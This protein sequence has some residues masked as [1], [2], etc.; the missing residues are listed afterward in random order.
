MNE[1]LEGKF[2]HML[3]FEPRI[4]K[5]LLFDDFSDTDQRLDQNNIQDNDP[6]GGDVIR[7]IQD[8]GNNPVDLNQG[9]LSLLMQS[10][11]PW[12][13]LPDQNQQQP[14]E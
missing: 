13:H 1:D 12:N 7:Q 5:K 11:M 8:R 4:H 9:G 3:P 14:P 6:L 2:D 10:L